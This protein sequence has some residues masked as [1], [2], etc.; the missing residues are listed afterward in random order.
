MINN[1]KDNPQIQQASLADLHRLN[2]TLSKY[3]N[4][5]PS[6]VNSIILLTTSERKTAAAESE[7]SI[8]V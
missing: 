4:V 8:L 3:F 1:N 6:I 7:P 5:A 2:I